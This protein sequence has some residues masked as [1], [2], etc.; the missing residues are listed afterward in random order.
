MTE[1]QRFVDFTTTRA[2]QK[3]FTAACCGNAST[4]VRAA[5]EFL[6]LAVGERT[7][8]LDALRGDHLVQRLDE[9]K[10]GVAD[11]KLSKRIEGFAAT[12]EAANSKPKD[13]SAAA[14]AFN[15]AWR[16][17]RP[18]LTKFTAD[19]ER[20]IPLAD[21]YPSLSLK[22]VGGWQVYDLL[23]HFAFTKP[24]EPITDSVGSLQA[25]EVTPILVVG[26]G[27]QVLKFVV[28]ML[29]GPP[30]L[31][32]PDWWPMGL[33]SF[34]PPGAMAADP[35]AESQIVDFLASIQKVLATENA[36]KSGRLRWRLEPW[37][38]NERLPASLE[39]RSA[40][41]AAAC[42][43]RAVY[44]RVAKPAKP[45]LS[46][47]YAITATV[48]PGG[49]LGIIKGLPHKCGAAG[50][51][52]LTKVLVAKNQPDLPEIP[53]LRVQPVATVAEAYSKLKKLNETLEPYLAHLDGL[54][55]QWDH[56]T[57]PT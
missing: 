28:E 42:A 13:F 22:T 54:A 5:Y 57:T 29:P 32:T 11:D 4:L 46:V 1:I 10:R 19:P 50:R 17:D 34:P 56:R 7:T 45:I 26:L 23:W 12:L 30:G 18:D 9:V 40:E 39:G 44:E 47:K 53:G 27:A 6:A 24:G 8:L 43:A 21:R 37:T 41:A 31:V 36:G 55:A 35:D 14:N 20:P 25:R 38:G 33:I 2:D 15:E 3:M 52:D 51:A 49:K 16:G 48:E